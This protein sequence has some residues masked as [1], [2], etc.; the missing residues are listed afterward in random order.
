MSGIAPAKMHADHHS[1]GPAPV[2]V[3][4]RLAY[5]S[6]NSSAQFGGLRVRSEQRRETLRITA[7]HAAFGRH[8][9][10]P[11]MAP[12]GRQASGVAGHIVAVKQK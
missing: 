8:A 10:D 6:S 3:L 12:G 1:G 2:I 9:I 4:V 5:L 11:N 7:R